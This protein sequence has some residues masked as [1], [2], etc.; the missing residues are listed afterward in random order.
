MGT[1]VSVIRIVL[2]VLGAMAL[3]LGPVIA[4]LRGPRV[5]IRE[6]PWAPASPVPWTFATVGIR[7][8]P[9]PRWIPFLARETALACRATIQFYRRG[10]AVTSP[11]AGRWSDR[12]EPIRAELVDPATGQVIGMLAPDLIPESQVYD[13]VAGG[14]WEE[15]AVAVLRDGEAYAWGAESYGF[16]NWRNPEWKLERGEYDVTVSAAAS[17]KTWTRRFRLSYLSN[18]MNEFRLSPLNK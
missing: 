7:N 1:G 10:E 5:Q 12:P 18:R 3:V 11:I 15:V 6:T 9:P 4:A 14:R 2:E 13:L 8:A 17:G 16:P